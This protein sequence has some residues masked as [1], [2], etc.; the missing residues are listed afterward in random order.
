MNREQYSNLYVINAFNIQTISSDTTTSGVIIDTQ[1]FDSLLFAIQ[2]GTITTG[3][4]TPV[5]EDGDAANL[6]DAADV[7]DAYL[8]PLESAAAFAVTDDNIV[9]RIAYLGTKRYVRLKL[10]TAGSTANLVV[11]ATAILANAE[12][13]PITANT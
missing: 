2:S 12:S 1:G 13:K 10:V 5:L 6:S 3:T 7:A 11:G 9:K 4:I 8:K